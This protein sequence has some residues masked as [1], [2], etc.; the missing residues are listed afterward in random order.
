[1]LAGFRVEAFVLQAEALY[2]FSAYYVGLDDL[3]YICI[4][5]LAIPDGIRINDEIGSV[6]ALIQ[7]AGLVRADSAFQAASG[8]LLL[9][10]FLQVGFG[11]WVAATSRVAGRTLVT[12]DEDVS[13]KFG[14]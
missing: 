2:R 1:M 3:V 11:G 4:C 7:A 5:D 10:E 8:K 12:A 6:L 13:F 14:H 9:K